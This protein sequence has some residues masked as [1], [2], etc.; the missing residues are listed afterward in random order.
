MKKNNISNFSKFHFIIIIFLFIQCEYSENNEKPNLK[1]ENESN[2]FKEEFELF[3][4]Y[5]YILN[6]DTTYFDSSSL[7]RRIFIKIN[8]NYIT[9][10]YFYKDSVEIS[11]KIYG[12]IALPF[13]DSLIYRIM[14]FSFINI[15]Q[16]HSKEGNLILKD[17]GFYSDKLSNTD[18]E[19][20]FYTKE[21]I[22]R[23]VE[24]EDSIKIFSNLDQEKYPLLTPK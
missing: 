14:P 5:F 4:P 13:A 1:S 15:K 20:Q 21:V 3:E 11:N 7:D 22:L 17:L 12:G 10:I 19:K 24:K 2:Y 8:N 9:K 6:N 23:K 18:F 16:S